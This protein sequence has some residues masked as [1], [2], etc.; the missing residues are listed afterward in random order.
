MPWNF[1]SSSYSN[2]GSSEGTACCRRRKSRTSSGRAA[3][4][5]KNAE[6]DRH[7]QYSTCPSAKDKVQPLLCRFP[8]QLPQSPLGYERAPKLPSSMVRSSSSIN[9][10]AFT[11]GGLMILENFCPPLPMKLLME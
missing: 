3:P 4:G 8:G 7:F 2:F 5:L 10:K 11:G 1:N 6:E 9:T